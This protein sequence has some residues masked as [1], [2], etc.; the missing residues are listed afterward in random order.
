M[1]GHEETQETQ[2][3]QEDTEWTD[4]SWEHA[5]IWTDAD[6]WSSDW[7]T[8]L[9]NDPGWEQAARQL[10][11]T[12][13]AQEQSNPTHGRSISMLGGLTICELSVDDEGQ[14]RE[15]NG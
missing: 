15:Q 4:T 8:N 13:P 1:E 6:W 9:W 7:S 14:R 11:S 3:S 5:D 12:Q 2:T 10:P